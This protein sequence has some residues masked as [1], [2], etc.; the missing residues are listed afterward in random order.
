MV[1]TTTID[2]TLTR[3]GLPKVDSIKMDIEGA[4]LDA[5]RGGEASIRKHRPRLTISLYHNP[6]DIEIIPRYLVSLDLGYRFYLDH[7]TIY[8]NETVLFG[9]PA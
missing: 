5:L 4:E 6:E 8:N 7:H 2:E 1:E 3:L 9:V